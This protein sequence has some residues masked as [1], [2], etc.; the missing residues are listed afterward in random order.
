M[1][2]AGTLTPGDGL[3]LKAFTDYPSD[4]IRLSYKGPKRGYHISCYLGVFIPDEDGPAGANVDERLNA[5]GWVFD[6]ERAKSEYARAKG[7]RQDGAASD[8]GQG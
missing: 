1:V 3:L 8:R 5:L 6:P 4:T 7:A 2:G